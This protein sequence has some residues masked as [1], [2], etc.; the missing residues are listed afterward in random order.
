M[1]GAEGQQGGQE[2]HAT[3]DSHGGQQPQGQGQGPAGMSGA[4]ADATGAESPSLEDVA[5]Q[6]EVKSRSRVSP[7]C[8]SICA[9]I[10]LYIQ[11]G[12]VAQLPSGCLLLPL[13]WCMRRPDTGNKEVI[14]LVYGLIVQSL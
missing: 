10:N 12:G 9:P 8:E 2:S 13:A 11:V 4:G 5:A 1:G 3:L 14:A 7:N 6:H